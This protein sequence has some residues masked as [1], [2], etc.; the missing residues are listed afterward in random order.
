MIKDRNVGFAIEIDPADAERME[1]LRKAAERA[2][3]GAASGVSSVSAV[4][5][6]H[7]RGPGTDRSPNTAPR[8]IQAPAEPA[9]VNCCRTWARSSPWPAAR[10][11]WG[12]PPRRSTSPSRWPSLG[13][14]GRHSGCRCLWPLAAAHVRHHRQANQ[15]LPGQADRAARGLWGE[16]DVDGIHG[17]RG[18][19]HDLARPDGDGRARADD[20]GSRLGTAGRPGRG[21]AAG[22]RAMHS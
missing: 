7:N 16:G 2:V 10:V 6:A 1:P 11:G 9:S 13:K 4:L 14:E 15:P 8:G 22:N 21:H 19:G 20:A 5:T 18:H 12:S 3:M 17:G